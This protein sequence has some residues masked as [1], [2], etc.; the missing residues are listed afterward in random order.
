ME[1]VKNFFVKIFDW[2]KGH[3]G[4]TVGIVVAIIAVIVCLSVFTGGPKKAVKRYIKA[5][6]KMNTEKVIKCM[7][8]AG[9]EAWGWKYDEDDFSEEDYDEFMK[10]YKEVDEEEIK[11]EK[12]YLKKSLNSG[13]DDI[14]EDYKKY[15]MTLEEIKSVKKLG[16][17][18]YC[19][20][21]KITLFA[22]PEDKD[23]DEID[24][25]DTASFI[26]YKNKL[27]YSDFMQKINRIF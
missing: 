22:K 14:K 23:E 20:K 24:K 25:T 21:A 12:K 5:M 16:K 13:F 6:N 1:K 8:F 27:I 7:D 4:I 2:V 17:D 11:D 19:V 18:L 3:I 9:S 10:D 26:V 15:K